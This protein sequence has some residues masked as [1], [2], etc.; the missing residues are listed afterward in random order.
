MVVVRLTPR[1]GRPPLVTG[2]RGRRE[3]RRLCSLLTV[4]VLAL[5]PFRKGARGSCGRDGAAVVGRRRW[6]RRLE[7]LR[8][9]AVSALAVF[10]A[11]GQWAARG[12][13]VSTRFF[14]PALTLSVNRSPIQYCRLD[15]F[16]VAN[17]Q[18]TASCN[19][20]SWFTPSCKIG[21]RKAGSV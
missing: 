1:V 3:I 18:E 21:I 2:A 8:S 16:N 13:S 20:R 5:L 12:G 17:R 6:R 10:G 9:G 11:N 7:Q 19:H 14:A 4:R 15:I